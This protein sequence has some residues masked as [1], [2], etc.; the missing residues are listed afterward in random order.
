MTG[1]RHLDLRSRGEEVD[2]VTLGYRR[3]AGFDVATPPLSCRQRYEQ[4]R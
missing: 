2:E 4:A 1:A 3:I